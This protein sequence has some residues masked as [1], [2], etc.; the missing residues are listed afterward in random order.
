MCLL[1]RNDPY[2]T[3][4]KLLKTLLKEIHD[5][6]GSCN[7]VERVKQ[8]NSY[9]KITSRFI[10][11]WG[12]KGRLNTFVWSSNVITARLKQH[13]CLVLGNQRENINVEYEIIRYF[14]EFL[15]LIM[16]PFRLGNVWHIRFSDQFKYIE[17]YNHLVQLF[18]VIFYSLATEP[19]STQTEHWEQLLLYKENWWHSI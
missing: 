5:K 6:N 19:Y 7:R 15:Y 9:V 18:L 13:L 10:C 8:S 4:H 2:G 17:N 14:D 1:W 11:I 3:R 16:V 12:R